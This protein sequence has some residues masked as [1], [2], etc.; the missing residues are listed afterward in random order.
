[1][2]KRK[3]KLRVNS[4][5]RRKDKVKAR[6]KLQQA[7]RERELGLASA[8]A[9]A[10]ALADKAAMQVAV[11]RLAGTPP[12]ARRSATPVLRAG[13]PI[14][15]PVSTVLEILQSDPTTGTQLIRIPIPGLIP[16]PPRR[17]EQMQGILE[18]T[19]R[20]K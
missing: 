20:T 9:V 1:M 13:Q 6:V 19:A 8:K 17:L 10:A 15:T 7:E 2:T 3:G 5:A 4:K 14:V 18:V 16:S 12:V 11:T